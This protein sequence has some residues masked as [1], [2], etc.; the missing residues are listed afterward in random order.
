[1]RLCLLR[2]KWKF[3]KF[4]EAA[5]D[6]FHSLGSI[7][8]DYIQKKGIPVYAEDMTKEILFFLDSVYKNCFLPR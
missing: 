8:K 5:W 7:L 2:H 3:L 1:M 4:N 6:N